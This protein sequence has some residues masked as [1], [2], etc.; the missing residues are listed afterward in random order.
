MGLEVSVGVG[1]SEC[2]ALLTSSKEILW[3]VA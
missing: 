3:E 1:T 2:G